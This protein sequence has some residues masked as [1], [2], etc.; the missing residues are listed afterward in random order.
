MENRADVAS[1]LV[2]GGVEGE[3]G[4][5]SVGTD[6]ASV[7]LDADNIAAGKRALVDSGGGDPDIAFVVEY[8]QVSA[9]SRRKAAVI[10][11]L[12]KHDELVGGVQIFYVHCRGPL[13]S[14]FSFGVNSPDNYI[15]VRRESKVNDA[16][17]KTFA[18]TG[19]FVGRVLKFSPFL[20]IAPT[21]KL[22]HRLFW[23]QK[24]ENCLIKQICT[25][26]KRSFLEGHTAGRDGVFFLD[27]Q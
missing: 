23:G 12:H 25:V 6:A 22:P 3:L 8:R 15:L 7:G 5:G 2:N 1:A 20:R 26:K 16:C 10:D 21:A 11:S 9:G 17:D 14:F 24:R 13:L 4:R 27:K 19:L 18:K